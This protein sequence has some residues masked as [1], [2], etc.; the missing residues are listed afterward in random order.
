MLHQGNTNSGFTAHGL[1]WEPGE[2]QEEPEVL[3]CSHANPSIALRLWLFFNASAIEGRTTIRCL[4][5]LENAVRY[6]SFQPYFGAVISFIYICKLC[7]LCKNVKHARLDVF[8]GAQICP[9][10][11]ALARLTPGEL[12]KCQILGENGGHGK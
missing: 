10:V 11:E 8:H 12:L 2:D 7:Y 9:P 5:C 1:R 6:V 4:H 3:W